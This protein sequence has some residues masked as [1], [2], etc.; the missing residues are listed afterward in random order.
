MALATLAELKGY[1]SIPVTQTSADAELLRTLEMASATAEQYVRRKLE[2]GQRT[3][4][5][6]GSD[7]S[8]LLLR[9]APVT[10]V[11][12]LASA[13]SLILPSV[14]GGAGYVFDENGIYLTGWQSFQ[15]GR[16]N[17]VV[18]YTGGYSPIPADIVHAVI[19]IAAQ[20]FREK[21][22]I[23]YQS[24]SLAGETV[25]FLRNGLPDSAKTALGPYRRMYLCD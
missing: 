2:L 17:I 7:G 11:A 20:A 3:E 12:S 19:E 4:I 22:W 25:S 18:T 23:G 1:L 9:D 10:A 24:K 21:D 6:S 14:D 8:E 5:R 13:G 16:K 15:F